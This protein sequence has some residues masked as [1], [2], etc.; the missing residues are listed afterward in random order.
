M[1]AIGIKDGIYL[2]LGAIGVGIAKYFDWKQGTGIDNQ[3]DGYKKFFEEKSSDLERRLVELHTID[4]KQWKE[5]DA[6]VEWEKAHEKE[7]AERRTK[8]EV[9]IAKVEG[10]LTSLADKLDLISDT[11]KNRFDKLE[12]EL[13]GK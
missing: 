3:F 5:I 8:L 4:E 11:M 9:Q 12:A 10:S 13:K 1:D 6:G 2:A 7:S